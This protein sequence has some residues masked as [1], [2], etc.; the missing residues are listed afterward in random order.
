MIRKNYTRNDRLTEVIETEW[1]IEKLTG[2]LWFLIITCLDTEVVIW[3]C[4]T[5]EIK[6]MD[7]D[8]TIHKQKE[9]SDSSTQYE[10]IHK[11]ERITLNPDSECLITIFWHWGQFCN[12]FC[13][14]AIKHTLETAG[15]SM[16]TACVLYMSQE[17]RKT[18]S[19][20]FSVLSRRFK[21]DFLTF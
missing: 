7:E 8:I 15:K 2:S 11:H 19:R 5:T 1:H 12:C 21:W 3:A 16:D 18:P 13:V 14:P 20:I 6:K 17:V 9:P 4:G 10:V